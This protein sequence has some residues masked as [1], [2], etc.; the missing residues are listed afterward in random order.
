MRVC[1]ITCLL[2]LG[3]CGHKATVPPELLVPP[4]GYVGATPRTEGQIVAAV[5]ADKR[6]L[7]Q[8]VLQLESIDTLL[9]AG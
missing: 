4:V 7:G 3:G 2:L 8:C 9:S 6:A 1:L 5:I